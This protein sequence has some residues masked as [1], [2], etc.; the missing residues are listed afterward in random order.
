VKEEVDAL[1]NWT[2]GFQ[3]Q[4]ETLNT[5]KLNLLTMA[6]LIHIGSQAQISK[7]TN[8]ETRSKNCI[9]TEQK[10]EVLANI[11]KVS[12]ESVKISKSNPLILPS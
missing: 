9:N 6:I 12:N 1:V 2:P 10:L 7:L 11:T 8:L 4:L 5:S 3:G